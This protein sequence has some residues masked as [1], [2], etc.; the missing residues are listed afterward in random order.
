MRRR[1]FTI[2]SVL[3]LLLCA[4]TL[5]MWTRSYSQSELFCCGDDRTCFLLETGRGVLQLTIVRDSAVPGPSIPASRWGHGSDAPSDLY[6]L[7]HTF[8]GLGWGRRVDVPPWY[9]F[10]PSVTIPHGYLVALFAVLPALFFYQ[11]LRSQY[12]LVSGHCP[13][14]GYDLRATPDRCPECGTRLPQ[15]P[16]TTA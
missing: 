16:N 8:M 2:A 6:P 10:R 14:C 12:R 9:S 11:R 13:L 5:V 3:S 4:A 7:P 1:L 15:K